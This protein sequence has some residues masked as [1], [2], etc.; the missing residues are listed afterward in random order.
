MS[1]VKQ[2]DFELFKQE[3]KSDY[4]LFT[5]DIKNTLENYFNKISNR[6]MLFCGLFVVA[7]AGYFEYMRIAHIK[8]SKKILQKYTFTAHPLKNQQGFVIF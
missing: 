3:M 8:K 6:V 4:A 7:F 2:K 1:E 5:Q